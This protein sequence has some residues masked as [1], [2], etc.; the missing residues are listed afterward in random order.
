MDLPRRSKEFAM[1]HGFEWEMM[2]QARAREVARRNR[3]SAQAESRESS[4]TAPPK[5]AESPVKDRIPEPV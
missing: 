4:T 2:M 1:C 5:P 3:D